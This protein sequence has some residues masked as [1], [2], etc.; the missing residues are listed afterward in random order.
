MIGVLSLLG[1]LRNR[2]ISFLSIFLLLILVISLNY[3]SIQR[4]FGSIL[5]ETDLL[6]SLS[7]DNSLPAYTPYLNDLS[8]YPY[9]PVTNLTKAGDDFDVSDTLAVYDEFSLNLSYNPITGDFEDNFT[10]SDLSSSYDESLLK[11]NMTHIQAKRDSYVI[12]DVQNGFVLFDGSRPAIAQS[13][14][15]KWEYAMFYGAEMHL[16]DDG[17]NLFTELELFVVKADEFTGAPDLS[18]NYSNELN[19]PYDN[20]NRIPTTFTYYD[21]EDIVLE[22]GKYFVVGKLT[23]KDWIGPKFFRWYRNTLSPYTSDTYYQTG[24]LTWELQAS[25]DHTFI[26]DL[27]PT[28]QNGTARVFDNLDDITMKDNDLE[29]SSIDSPI[30]SIGSHNITCDTSLE[31]AFNNSYHFSNNYIVT[32]HYSAFNGTAGSYSIYWNLTWDVS[33][34]D[35]SPYLTSYRSIYIEVEDD[36]FETP[37]CYYNESLSFSATLIDNYYSCILGTNNSAGTFRIETSSRNY[38]QNLDLSDGEISTDFFTLGYWTTDSV[39]STGHEG[40][41]IYSSITLLEATATGTLNFTLFNPEGN[42]IPVKTGLPANLT[43][44]DLT[45]YTIIEPTA[46]SPGLFTSEI[47]LDPS[48]YGSD[49]EGIWTVFVYWNNGT[50]V[51]LFSVPVYIQSSTYFNVEWEEIP[52]YNNWINDTN[53]LIVRQNGDELVLNTSYYK[54]SEPFFTGNGKLIEDTNITFT[55]SWGESGVLLNENDYHLLS[56]QTNLTANTYSIGLSTNGVLLENHYVNLDLQVFNIFSIEVIESSI[57]SNSTD[58]L[59]LSF[60]LINETDT[61][62]NP[63]SVVESELSIMILDEE[64]DQEYYYIEFE[65]GI[66][67]VIISTQAIKFSDFDLMLNVTKAHFKTDYTNNIIET[68]FDIIVHQVNPSSGI[69]PYLIGVIGGST[70]VVGIISGIVIRRLRR[71]KEIVVR[72]VDISEGSNLVS[73]FENIQSLRKVLFT[74]TATSLPVYEYDI[75]YEKTVDTALITGFLSVVETMGKEIGGT[76]TGG[77]KK[78]EYGN[79]VVN[80]ASSENYSVYLFTSTEINA[81][82]SNRLFNLVIWFENRFKLVLPWDGTMDEFNEKERI[83]QEKIFEDLYVWLFFPLLVNTVKVNEIYECE[84]INPEIADFIAKSTS[85]KITKLIQTFQ[86]VEL[87]DIL[88]TVFTCVDNEF[89]LQKKSM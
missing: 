5:Q 44:T 8:S 19:G 79:F 22:Q 3:T 58:D 75:Q 18:Y 42:I 45:E 35:P 34:V 52:T 29:I 13:F 21:F 80:T 6:D 15:V 55:A 16:A 78:L 1:K 72:P 81:E 56:Y 31:I 40:S 61:N 49:S 41:T 4:S 59:K 26:V 37:N 64:V 2:T 28:F 63:M 36:W 88:Y 25:V 20:T 12:E 86:E 54:L 65:D 30:T 74:H 11:Y 17:S 32:T 39:T 50:E 69:P 76:G 46:D 84:G 7:V 60:R 71:N 27:L 9:T 83:I 82:I 53:Q 77:I 10:L 89:L 70:L 66:N 51:G 85:V 62:R 87:K 57:E 43:F 48:V 73:L 47:T 23:E 38:I 68:T 33:S 67:T 14:E 24:S